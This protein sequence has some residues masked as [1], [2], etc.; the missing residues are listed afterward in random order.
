MDHRQLSEQIRDLIKD[1]PD[2]P[3]PGI[4][5][6]DLTPVFAHGPSTAALAGMFA[7]RYAARNVDA[8][9]AI[10]SRGFLL[11]APIAAKMEKPLVLVRKPGKLPRK[12]RSQ[13]YQLEYG[14]DTLEMHEDA[15]QAGQR[16]VVIDDLLAT[17][18]TAAATCNLVRQT[19]AEIAEVAFLVELG[20]LEGRQRLAAHDCFALVTY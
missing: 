3:K 1:V 19:Q 14:E 17:G 11:G 15:L 10:E 12:V 4:V 13:S 5:F 8:I 9:V 20:F 7:E 16:V 2:F 6:K 18:G